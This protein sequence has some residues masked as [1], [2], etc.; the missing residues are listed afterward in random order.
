MT[1]ASV[2]HGRAAMRR[3]FLRRGWEL[4]SGYSSVIKSV[5]WARLNLLKQLRSTVGSLGTGHGGAARFRFGGS[6]Q[7]AFA[8]LTSGRR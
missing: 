4:V 6:A 2:S 7:P 5:I 1:I 8:D 3:E